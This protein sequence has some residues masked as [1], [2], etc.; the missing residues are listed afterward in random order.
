MDKNSHSVN[1]F[2]IPASD[3][4]RARTFYEKIFDIEMQPLPVPE[5]EMVAFPMEMGNGKVHGALI[6]HEMYTP[7]ANGVTIYLNA[8]PDIQT[9]VDRIE[10]AGGNIVI[11]RTQISEE[12]GYMAFFMDSEGNRMALHAQN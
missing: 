8:D 11:P 6:K 12:M 2:E 7:S 3:M 10:Q 1:W 9:V 5:F 4:D